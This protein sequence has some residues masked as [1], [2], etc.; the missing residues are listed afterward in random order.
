MQILLHHNYNSSERTLLR[1][2][3]FVMEK[4]KVKKKSNPWGLL[5]L[6]GVIVGGLRF[7]L[8]W[9]VFHPTA[10]LAYTPAAANLP[11]EDVTFS[12]TDG[13]RLH[14]WYVPAPSARATLLFFHGNAGNISH[15]I[16]SIEIFHELGLSVFIFDYR[17]YGQSDGKPSIDGTALDARAAW[18]W[19]TEDKKIPSGNIVVFGR[20]MG[21]AVAMELLRDVKPR[22]LILES[23]FSSLPEMNKIP[24]LAP[25]ARLIVGDVW[26][27]AEVAATLAI[28]TLCIHSQDDEIVPYRLG[29]RLYDAV[30]GEKEFF[31]IHGD[32]NGGFENSYDTYVPALGA[33]VTKHF[34]LQEQ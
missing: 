31:E 14:G 9:I 29:R 13:V 34:S 6:L 4:N 12:T 1:E 7:M 32:H 21:G 10:Q 16:S 27:S 19:L 2:R 3:K 5:L 17:G 15:R 18:R 26:N 24:F 28:P 33:F 23:T 8:P 22:A 20:S 30:A 11:F 25:L